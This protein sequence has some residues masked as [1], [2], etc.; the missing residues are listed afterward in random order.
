MSRSRSSLSR[1]E[2]ETFQSFVLENKK[3]LISNLYMN[4]LVG[5]NRFA[6]PYGFFKRLSERLGKSPAQS[7]QQ[8]LQIE[9]ELYTKLLEIPKEHYDLYSSIL[10]FNTST[11][12]SEVTNYF[13]NDIFHF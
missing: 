8:F 3:R 10:K 11:G 13:S 6:R 7:K 4:I 2:R 9:Q 12:G 1:L 5:F